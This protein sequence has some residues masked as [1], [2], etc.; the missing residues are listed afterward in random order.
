MTNLQQ[1]IITGLLFGIVLIS[2]ILF[3][4]LSF[5]LLFGIITLLGVM[6]FYR[7]SENM[8][9]KAQTT[10]GIITSLSMY[11]IVGLQTQHLLANKWL[12]VLLPL[13]FVIFIAELYRKHQYPFANIAITLLG[14]MYVAVPFTLLQLIVMPNQLTFAPTNLLGFFFILWANDSGAYFVGR[15][16]GKTKL[17]E[18]ISPNKTWEGTVGGTL[19]ALIVAA[20]QANYFTDLSTTNWLVIAVI[21]TITGSL[22]D[23]VESLLKRSINVK[24]SG[25]IL[26][27]HGGILDRF[28]GLLISLPF[29]YSYLVLFVYE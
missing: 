8:N 20:I 12:C 13:V 3:S 16:L 15:K 25:T 7:L 4:K 11:A 9:L 19:L 18:R 26:P 5:S 10:L 21:I 23:L 22:G 2:A 27:G 28:D 14:I 1:R 6:E 29:V 24:D 17:F